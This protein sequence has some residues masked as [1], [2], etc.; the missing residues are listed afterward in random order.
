MRLSLIPLAT[1]SAFAQTSGLAVSGSGTLLFTSSLQHE[2]ESVLNRSNKIFQWDGER[3]SLFA[4]LS[5]PRLPVPGEDDDSFFD[6]TITRPLIS[7]DGKIATY[8]VNFPCR[9][10]GCFIARATD[11]Y[12]FP[13]ATFPSLAGSPQIS[14]NGRFV[15]T[16]WLTPVG[17]TLYVRYES[18]SVAESGLEAS[19]VANPTNQPI[20][21][22]G[23]FLVFE[24]P[25]RVNGIPV[26]NRPDLLVLSGDASK[27]RTKISENTEY[28]SI[29][30]DGRRIAFARVRGG[31]RE[32]VLLNRD[33]NAERVLSA[34]PA[35][36]APMF[37]NDGSLLWSEL[38]AD[39][40][41][42]RLMFEPVNGS[43]R[44][45]PFRDS[46]LGEAV[47]S[48]NGKI[49]YAATSDGRIV[50]LST[51]T[52]EIRELVPA[53]PVAELG[54]AVALGSVIRLYGR[55]SEKT[56]VA[57][58]DSRLPVVNRGL[59]TQAIQAPWDLRNISGPQIITVK[60]P[61]SRFSSYTRTLFVQSPRLTFDRVALNPNFGSV[62]AVAHHDFRGLV[63]T[64]DPAAPGETIHVFARN[65]GPVDQPIA[66]GAVSPADPP[67]RII[68][69]LA[70]YLRELDQTTRRPKERIEGLTIPF[71]GLTAGSVG[72]YHLDITMP[73]EWP[74]GSHEL[75]CQLNGQGSPITVAIGR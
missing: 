35:S 10:G 49:V 55:P 38:D 61:G 37:A 45:L 16:R 68:T 11:V 58:G 5:P 25:E 3:I 27:T 18:G 7:G 31:E 72:G 74:A 44:V 65:L 21:D 47:I 29:S 9:G 20:A 53:F 41:T 73:A 59:S 24:I 33:T 12:T 2:S 48:G 34:S 70:C 6:R 32:L 22:T 71:A 75:L 43:A 36:L 14:S 19:P 28:A 51:A 69:P 1:L 26:R 4:S 60:E 15:L 39:G 56:E 13:P 17:S 62:P 46:L 63:T 50:Q 23:E 42:I 30:P 64:A 66:T 52:D 40:S 8:G 57:D 67:A 54:A